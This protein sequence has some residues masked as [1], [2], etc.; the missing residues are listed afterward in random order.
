MLYFHK[1]GTV[2]LCELLL[3]IWILGIVYNLLKYLIK[4]RGVM[5]YIRSLPKV[6]DGAGRKMLDELHNG[7]R[8]ELIKT[9]SVKSPF[10]IGI[11]KKR[12]LLP[13]REYSKEEVRYILLHEYTHLRNN[14]ILLKGLITAL[15]W[16]YWWNPIV[17]LLKRELSQSIEIRCDLSVAG[18]L[19]ENER[20]DYLSIMLDAFRESRQADNYIGAVGL[21]E[22]H[23][24]SL[25][26]RF[27]IVADTKVVQK[28]RA[29]MFAGFIMLFLLIV[30]Y[31]FILQSKF[32]TPMSEIETG[33]NIYH[34]DTEN[35]YIIKRGDTYFMHTDDD[36]EAVLSE[37]AAN[38]LMEEGFIMKG[39]E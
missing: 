24:E 27:R 19:S 35:A 2:R 17:Y 28:K 14:D 38:M 23:S 5:C 16:I 31:S 36:M 4:Y 11:F 37:T 26:E 39:G 34:V 8:I 12:I 30:S 22:N 32:E 3:V 10:C 1:V 25:L 20:A 13:D 21:T 18:H 6:E 7:T 29:N 9:P 15:C 33:E